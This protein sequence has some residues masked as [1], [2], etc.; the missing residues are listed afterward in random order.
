MQKNGRTVVEL[1]MASDLI[2]GFQGEI[3]L[4]NRRPFL[5]V[6]EHWLDTLMY[7]GDLEN[8]GVSPR[9]KRIRLS[10]LYVLTNASMQKR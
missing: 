1:L 10:R 8:V 9:A 6:F 7:L 2:S 5:V 4:V 3:E